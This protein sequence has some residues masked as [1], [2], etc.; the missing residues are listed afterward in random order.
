MPEDEP[1]VVAGAPNGNSPWGVFTADHV[2][3]REAFAE[4]R[5]PEFENA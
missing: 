3:A 5:P 2:E 1:T 4:R